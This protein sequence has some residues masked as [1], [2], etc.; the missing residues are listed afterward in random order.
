MPVLLAAILC[1]IPALIAPH[2]FFRFDV[3]PKVVLLLLGVALAVVWGAATPTCMALPRLYRGSR[4]SRWFLL[5]LCGMALSLAISTMVSVNFDLSFGGSAWRYWGLITQLAALG[6]AYI[7]CACCAGEPGR[8]RV[9]LR[10]VSVTGLIVAGYG[11]AQYFGFDPLLDPH[12]YHVGEGIWRIVRPP[13]TLGHADYAANW[14]LFVVFAAIALALSDPAVLWRCLAWTSAAAASAAI[15]LS[16]T[17]AAVIGLAAGA[18]F[19][20]ASRPRNVRRYLAWIA[21][22]VVAGVLFYISPPAAQL[23]ARV[24]WTLTEP[25]GG[26]RLLLWRDTLRMS[27][28][29]WLAGYGPETFTA[30]FPLHESADL[31]RAFPDFY[32]ESPHNIFLDALV[33]EGIAA[34]L[35]L[36]ALAASGFLAFRANRQNPMS[37]ALAAGLAGMTVSEQFTC[38]TL[39]TALAYYVA[40]ALPVS[41]SIPPNTQQQARPKQLWLVLAVPYAAVLC[42]FAVRLWAAESLLAGVRQDLDRNLVSEAAQKY[43]AY[44]RWR[45]PGPAAD[46]WYARRLLQIAGSSAAPIVR[47]QAFQEAG[48]AAQRAT[49]TSADRFN[50]YYSLAAFYAGQNDFA[51]TEQSLRAAIAGAPNWF[52]P[53]WMLAQVLWAAGRMKEAGQEAGTAAA[54]DGGRDAEVNRTLAGI[55]SVLDSPRPKPPH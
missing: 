24:H 35:L 22:I 55:R 29:R 33:S 48:A 4:A 23:R 5:V 54:L 3:T 50:A 38:F 20:M 44:Q 32:H 13:A 17:R 31:A 9:L 10:G 11:I 28:S 16:G 53:H 37:A 26:A 45:C 30:A 46:L 7:V 36:V 52:K 6:F 41:L 42:I 43:T 49:H 18:L 39:P 14:L 1:V 21:A 15:V 27:Q 34:P 2:W 12:G 8:V 19:L 25:A 40:I 51:H 47:I